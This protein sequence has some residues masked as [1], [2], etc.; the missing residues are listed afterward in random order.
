[1]TVIAE[2]GSLNDSISE[3]YGILLPAHILI[4]INKRDDNACLLYTSKYKI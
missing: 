4:A 3:I 1:M 2:S